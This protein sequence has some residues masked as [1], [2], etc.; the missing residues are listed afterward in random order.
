MLVINTSTPTQISDGFWWAALIPEVIKRMQMRF[1]NLPTMQKML[2]DSGFRIEGMTVPLTGI[3]Q[4]KNYLDTQAALTAAWRAGDSSFS[5]LDAKG[6]DHFEAQIRGMHESG[7][8]D[9]FMQEREAR[10]MEVG[11]SIFIYGVK[12]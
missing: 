9:R 11:Q 7:K 4:G 2:E 8:I 10:R 5:L 12:E 1:F 6:I 3:L